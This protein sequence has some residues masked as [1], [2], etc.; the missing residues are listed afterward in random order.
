MISNVERKFSTSTK[1]KSLE[2]QGVRS[3]IE[4]R[5]YTKS[6]PS[7]DDSGDRV[8]HAV[9]QV[10]FKYKDLAS[11]LS[12]KVCYVRLGH[13]NSHPR[14]NKLPMWITACLGNQFF[15]RRQSFDS[16]SNEDVEIS[17]SLSTSFSAQNIPV[18]AGGTLHVSCSWE[19][20]RQLKSNDEFGSWYFVSQPSK[21]GHCI[22]EE[23]IQN[24]QAS[25]M[26]VTRQTARF[27]ENTKS[28]SPQK[29]Q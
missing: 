9:P 3:P 20:S 11:L 4:S 6:M 8:R 5:Q 16:T 28:S 23:D 12:L 26:I 17:M 29:C 2:K 18:H 24:P 10:V 14:N 19:T 21:R 27:W 15:C 25:K 7:L 1:R 22:V 13:F